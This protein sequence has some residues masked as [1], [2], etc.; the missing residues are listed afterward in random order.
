MTDAEGF[1]KMRVGIHVVGSEGDIRPLIAL[2]GGLRR[3][4]HDVTVAVH[5]TTPYD[6]GTLC[7]RLDVE[8]IA[9]TF[10]PAL[11]HARLSAADSS[12]WAIELFDQ[13][14]RASGHE[15]MIYEVALSLCR[16]NDLVIS[17]YLSYPTKA[18]A[19][20]TGAPHVA[21]QLTH[22]HT[23]TKFRP[24]LAHMP[25]LG[26]HLNPMLWDQLAE[27][28]DS[29]ARRLIDAFW[30][31]H[32]L[33]PFRRVTDLYFS[34]T[35]NVL[36]VSPTLCE[37]QPD[38]GDLHVVTGVL[39]I[40][41]EEE[42]QLAP[43]LARFISAGPPPIFMGFGSTQQI[44]PGSE[45]GRNMALLLDAAVGS[46]CRA[47]IQ[48]PL[49]VQDRFPPNTSPAGNSDVL[50]VGRVPYG[51][52]FAESA[53]VVHHGGAGTLHLA[54]RCARPSVVVPFTEHHWFLGFE[55]HRAGLAPR[56][57]RRRELTPAA[58]SEQI[59]QVLGEPVYQRRAAEVA[60]RVLTEAGVMRAVDV[61][62]ARV[63]GHGLGS[64]C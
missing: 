23:P 9:P 49:E 64:R 59:R 55:L 57:V 37:T 12:S 10:F 16:S 14:W 35:L 62:N 4:G 63:A 39:E 20:A 32:G 56:P 6:Y 2:G 28:H 44:Y 11:D 18:A 48:A 50:F 42:P 33:P 19:V 5:G 34:D 61:I 46:G 47:V 25:N 8:Y 22:E 36:A 31:R 29:A 41:A 43:E 1:S 3:A 17:H 38:W 15:D 30:N 54:M 13:F 26:P 7:R 58:L 24:P 27:M 21:V 52:M 45:A 60:P 53:A 51:R 40:P